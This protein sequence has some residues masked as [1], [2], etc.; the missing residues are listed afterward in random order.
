MI[1]VSE[2]LLLAKIRDFFREKLV[3][4]AKA[5]LAERRPVAHKEL[6]E[7]LEERD[8]TTAHHRDWRERYQLAGQKGVFVY[9]LKKEHRNEEPFHLLC[10]GCFGRGTKGILQRGTKKESRFDLEAVTV[11]VCAVC[12][13]DM[14]VTEDCSP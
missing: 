8:K 12:K 9:A 7:I 3:A 6:R 13:S 14:T 10:P 1:F 2:T 11:L 4:R 5:W